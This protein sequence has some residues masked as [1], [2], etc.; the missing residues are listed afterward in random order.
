MV[1]FRR[2]N[3]R[4]CTDPLVSCSVPLLAWC[5]DCTRSRG[6]HRRTWRPR[7]RS[8]R[9]GG[10]AGLRSSRRGDRWS[11]RSALDGRRTAAGLVRAD[12]ALGGARLSGRRLRTTDLGGARLSGRRLRTTHLGG[13]RLSGRRL[14]TTHLGDARLSGR[15][16]RTTHLGDARLSGRRLRTTHL[17]GGCGC[18][19]C[20]RGSAGTSW[21]AMLCPRLGPRLSPRRRARLRRLANLLPRRRDRTRR[22]SGCVRPTRCSWRRLRGSHPRLLYRRSSLA[23]LRPLG[24]PSKPEPGQKALFGRWRRRRIPYGYGALS[25][26][27][28]GR[29]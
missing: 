12:G 19:T 13:A 3:W 16:L 10:H 27:C 22:G 26:P 2:V 11:R 24:L 20:S 28:A 8:H 1:G 15:R 25:R 7:C 29:R 14:R 5:R 6:L 23:A 9:C 4:T 17:S 18:Q 21:G